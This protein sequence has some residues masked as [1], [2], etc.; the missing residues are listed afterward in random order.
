M[1]IQRG[2]REGVRKKQ[3]DRGRYRETKI[4]R[5]TQINRDIVTRTLRQKETEEQ[6]QKRR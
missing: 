3:A 1:E 2:G 4:E 5:Q 6:A